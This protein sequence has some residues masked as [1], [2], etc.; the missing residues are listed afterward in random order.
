MA[1]SRLQFVRM[2]AARAGALV[3]GVVASVII[4]RAL[5]PEARGTYYMAVTVGTAAM[6][7]GHLSIEQAQ[8]A[9]WSD[10]GRR[11]S[12]EGNS[13]PLGLMI[14]AGAALAAMAAAVVFQG[15]GNMP[16]LWLLAT[17]CVGVPLGV[18]VLYSS[19]IAVLRD[20]PHVAGLAPL[21]GAV[22]QCTCLVALGLTGHL[23]V[24]TVVV[25]W[26]VSFGVSLVVLVGRGG[27]T[28]SRPRLGLA[29][30]TCAKGL[31]LHAGSA[32]SYLLLRSDVFLLNALAG[33]RDVGIYTLAV[34]LAELSRI[35][36]DAFAQ[37][38]LPRQFDHD[39]E[40][41]AAVAARMVRL[42]VILGAVS[43]V[44][45]VI[46]VSAL[47]TPVYG[48]AYAEAAALVAWLVP[49]ILLLSAGRPV[50]TFLLRFRSARFVVLPSL[51]ALGVN[52][53]LNTM[54]IPLWGAAGCAIASTAAYATLVVLQVAHFA[55]ISGTPWRRLLPTSADTSRIT[56]S[57]RRGR[58]DLDVGRSR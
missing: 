35:G 50:A 20:R 39:M 49:G 46:A 53:G 48:H 10:K 14:G 12:L 11:A 7:L 58:G 51:L 43:V 56:S 13:V 38:T 24:Y 33:P 15:H 5:P 4:A 45:T 6:A 25:V 32:A 2:V 29:K 17:A 9:L 36:V 37:V 19:N 27:V 1:D 31:R 42:M 28:V 55:R 34:T 44:T 22:V 57:L 18:G 41:S 3:M 40:G 21:A 30:T 26:S 52:I 54:L 8:T 16:D 47:I 23:T